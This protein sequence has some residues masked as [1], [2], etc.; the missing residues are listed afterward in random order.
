MNTKNLT[1][2]TAY[3][4]Y[5]G[6]VL[7]FMKLQLPG[8]LWAIFTLT[9][10]PLLRYRQFRR[11]KKVVDDAHKINQTLFEEKIAIAAS[12]VMVILGTGLT[13]ILLNHVFDFQPH[14]FD[15]GATN[16]GRRRAPSFECTERLVLTAIYCLTFL[17]LITVMWSL[18]RHYLVREHCDDH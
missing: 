13:Y 8:I 11:W 14:N 10:G 15:C 9:V 12:T 7:I 1:I 6:C 5:F 16:F 4:L 18:A 17:S 3:A 2:A